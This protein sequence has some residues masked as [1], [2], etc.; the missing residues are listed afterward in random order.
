MSEKPNCPA[1]YLG[2]Q[3]G[4]EEMGLSAMSHIDPEFNLDENTLEV[5]FKCAKGPVKTT[6]QLI[7]C[8]RD[9]ELSEYVFT[10]THYGVVTFLVNLPEPGYYKLQIFGLPAKDDSKSLPNVY[11]Y[12]I[13]CTQ[14]TKPVFPFPQQ[15]ADWKDGCYLAEPLYLHKNSP[16]SNLK[17]KVTVPEAKGVAVVADGD[18]YH[19]E[20]VGNHWEA[21]ITLD[22]YRGQNKK[23]TLNANF[24]EDDT[25]FASLLKYNI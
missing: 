1:G 20:K 25:K 19:F 13:N 11:N 6:R 8:K 12:L 17:F 23:V 10:Q 16:L 4:F 15:F 18:W 22:K 9:I 2:P 5:K 3:K 7:S 21:T 24:V 14:V